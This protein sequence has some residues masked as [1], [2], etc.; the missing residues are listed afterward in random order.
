MIISL[1]AN[2]SKGVIFNVTE[3][4]RCHSLACGQVGLQ[5]Y[6]VFLAVA[7]L[8]RCYYE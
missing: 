2:K 3:L 5:V 8:G 7:F 6:K 1:R 4:F